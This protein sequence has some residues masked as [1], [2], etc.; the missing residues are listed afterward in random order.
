MGRNQLQWCVSRLLSPL[1]SYIEVLP[2]CQTDQAC[3]GFPLAGGINNGFT[4]ED[5]TGETA[6]MTCYTGGETV[7]NN[8]Q[9]CDVTS[10][11]HHICFVPRASFHV[12]LDRKIIDQLDGRKPQVTF[13]CEKSD[14]TCSFQFWVDQVESF[15]CAL[16]NCTSENKPGYDTNSTIYACDH[17]KC[18]CVPNRFICGEDG[19]VG[20]S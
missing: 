12:A 9:M 7:F 8:H 1:Y 4:D 11:Y 13:S 5:E 18:S 3:V 16:S 17:I 2:V 6:N 19:S 20:T 15:Y 10:A 14:A